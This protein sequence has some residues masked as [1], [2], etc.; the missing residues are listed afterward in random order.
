MTKAYMT[1]LLIVF[2]IGFKLG[3]KYILKG[4]ALRAEQLYQEGY[5]RDARLYQE[6]L[7][8]GGEENSDGK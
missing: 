8:Q 6:I 7:K 5:Y 2:L 3:K 4:L 1:L